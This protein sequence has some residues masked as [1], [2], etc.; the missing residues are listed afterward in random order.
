VDDPQEDRDVKNKRI[1]DEFNNWVIN[2]LYG[3][4]VDDIDDIGKF[5]MVVVGTVISEMCLV[6]ELEKR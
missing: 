6:V 2:T 4:I 3:S 5:K 1:I